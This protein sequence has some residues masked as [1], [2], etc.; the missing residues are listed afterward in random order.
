M[1]PLTRPHSGVSVDER[2]RGCASVASA[3]RCRRCR[4]V[5]CLRGNKGCFSRNSVEKREAGKRPFYNLESSFPKVIF[6]FSDPQKKKCLHLDK[7]AKVQIESCK[8]TC[9]PA[10]ERRSLSFKNFL[11]AN[12]WLLKS[13]SLL[14]E[15]CTKIA[16]Y[17]SLTK[18]SQGLYIICMFPDCRNAAE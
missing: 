11:K 6:F 3:C 13:Q 15:K 5:G 4:C 7:K 2:Y 8:N 18:S 9:V 1:T 17:Y 14:K 10:D 16:N 12:R